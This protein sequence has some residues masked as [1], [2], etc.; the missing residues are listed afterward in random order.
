[1][2][3][4]TILTLLVAVFYSCTNIEDSPE[5]KKLLLE[6]DSLESITNYDAVQINKYLQEFNEIQDNLN[7][8]KELENIITVKTSG[9]TEFDDN[10][11]TQI[12]EDVNLIYEIINKNRNTINELRNKLRNSDK[13]LFELEKMIDNLNNQLSFKNE[14]I[15]TLKLKLEK[16][17]IHIEILT[18][19]IENLEREN[20]EKQHEIIEKTEDI[21]TAY[22]VFGT[23]KELIEREV[24]TKEG[25][26]IGIGRI[27]KLR[28]DFNRDYFTKVDITKLKSIP[29]AAKKATIV[30]T[31]PSYSYKLT[32]NNIVEAIEILEPKEFW[33]ASKY[34]VIIVE[35]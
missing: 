27:K 5:Y 13:R 23:T 21:N 16:Q 34:L 4:I 11:K 35:Q 31:H 20:L 22:Y 30:T 1:M 14:E 17:N 7:R 32:G 2:K 19:N 10:F 6:K 3:K 28:E 8:I 12:N 33:S 24:L 25:G 15:E 26:F 18:V 9:Q 29:I